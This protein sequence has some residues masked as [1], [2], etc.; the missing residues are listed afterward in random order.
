MQ[1]EIPKPDV[2][3]TLRENLE[4]YLSE[5]QQKVDGLN[6]MLRELPS[7]L[8]DQPIDKVTEAL[9]IHPAYHRQMGSTTGMAVQ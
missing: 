1:I 5:Y 8:L 2:I 6:K 4:Q 9:T 3:P 7:S